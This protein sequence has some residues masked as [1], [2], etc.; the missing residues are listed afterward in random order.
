LLENLKSKN[1]FASAFLKYC[2]YFTVFALSWFLIHQIF[3]ISDG[4][5]DETEK[6][7][8]I[9]IFGNKVNTDGTLSD[10][11]TAR[12]KKGLSLYKDSLA[13]K[14]FVSGGVGKEDFPEATKMAEFLVNNGVS[15]KNI[16][17]DNAGNNTRL[18]AVNFYKLEGSNSSVI[19]VS[20]FYH[21][22]RAKLAFS[23]AGISD[24]QG[25]APDY[26]EMRDFYSLFREFFG[27][28]KYL[29]F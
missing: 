23:N 10:R 4:L 7:D 3:I 1:R 13:N 11:L 21:I 14:I 18:T 15:S 28:Y 19:L 5:T 6:S 25:A 12:M 17:I 22:T 2:K 20:Q 16:I 8:F 26:F 9:V 29:I 24:A 27:Y